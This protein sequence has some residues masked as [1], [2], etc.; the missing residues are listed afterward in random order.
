MD[1]SYSPDCHA[2]GDLHQHTIGLVHATRCVLTLVSSY[3]VAAAL[4]RRLGHTVDIRCLCVRIHARHRRCHHCHPCLQHVWPHLQRRR[5]VCL[6]VD[7]LQ[8]KRGCRCC[9]LVLLMVPAGTAGVHARN[10]E[11]PS[12]HLLSGVAATCRKRGS[13]SRLLTTRA[14]CSRSSTTRHGTW[15]TFPAWIVAAGS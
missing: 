10:S 6:R 11:C 3:V 8:Q 1:S 14:T 9:V 7:V 15:K 2:G 13:S 12:R 5:C 4:Y